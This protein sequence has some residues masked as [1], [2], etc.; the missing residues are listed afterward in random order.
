MADVHGAL[1]IAERQKLRGRLSATQDAFISAIPKIELHVHI[2][3][4]ITPELK[5]KFSQRNGQTLKHQRTGAAFTSLEELEDAHGLMKPRKGE[6]MDNAEETLSFFDAYYG[7]F[8]VLKTKQDYRD[9][10]M[11]YLERAAA[12]NVRYCELF[13]D[14]QGHTRVGTKWETMMEGFRE[15][16][17]VAAKDLSV[18]RKQ[19]T[20]KQC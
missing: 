16:Q 8:E 3:G 4:I 7:G 2:E 14:P 5:W 20:T 18:R 19:I 13:F 17:A 11:H 6:R 12:M 9:L 10:A 15:A 1:P